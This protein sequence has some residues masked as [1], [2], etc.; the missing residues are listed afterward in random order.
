[1]LLVLLTPGE[2]Q[3]FFR[4]TTGK[5][6]DEFSSP[7]EVRRLR[8][9][10]NG[11]EADY[12]R[13]GAELGWT[14]LLVS[15]ANGGGSI[16]GH[17]LVDLTMVAYEFGRHAAPGPLIATNIVAGAL[18]DTA[19][20]NGGAHADVLGALVAGTTI[21][22]WC[23]GEPRPNDKL[24]RV[25]LD[26]RVDGDHLVLNGAKRPVEAAAASQFLLVTG[27]TGA[28]LTQVLVPADTA[29]VS[30]T[31][32][33]SLDPTRHCATVTFTDVRVPLSAAVGVVGAADAQVA[34]QLL[35]AASLANS[36]AVGAMQTAFDI[37]LEWLGDRFSFGRPLASYQAL[38]HRMADMKH[39]LEASHAIS[40][41]AAIA[42]STG[43]PKAPAVVSAAKAYIG[44]Y[45][46]ELMQE[47]VQMHGGIGVTYEHDLHLYLRR[48]TMDRSM[49]G[50]PAE[51]RRRIA[52]LSIDGTNSED[53]A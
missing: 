45:G 17:G 32:L 4:E 51:H 23:Y 36:E 3:E 40:D 33:R 7:G 31:P 25:T 52:D 24:G 22:T 41:E 19:E 34:H 28:G 39:W 14:T 10:D 26:V 29:G 49:Y 5:F 21:A 46:S 30:I 13:R 1:V 15:E 47:C 8:D 18:S 12:W 35:V 50:T 11:F 16:S 44:Q 27:R 20:I 48:H 42:V 37:T 43:A 53:V 9:H 6:L 38:K 2:D